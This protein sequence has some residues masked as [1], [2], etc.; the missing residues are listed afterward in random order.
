[1]GRY[2]SLRVTTGR[3]VMMGSIGYK[4]DEKNKKKET[5]M[6]L[7]MHDVLY[8]NVC[9]ECKYYVLFTLLF[10]TNIKTVI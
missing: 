6:V 9:K 8:A 4:W 5:K 2:T 7:P 1:M 3:M 10:D